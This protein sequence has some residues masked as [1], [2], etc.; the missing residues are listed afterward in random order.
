MI[1]SRF[2]SCFAAVLLMTTVAA[3][4]TDTTFTFQGELN[5]NGVPANAAFNMVFSLF[6][7]ANG[8]ILIG[9]PNVHGAV[10]VVDGKFAAELDFGA[11]AF[12]DNRWLEIEINGVPL[13]PRTP[14]THAPY[15][16]QTRGIFVNDAGLVG[17]ANNNPQSTLQVTQT[18][19]FE[20]MLTVEQANGIWAF[21]IQLR[22]SLMK[23]AQLIICF[24]LASGDN[25]HVA[26]RRIRRSPFRVN[27]NSTE[28]P[29]T[30]RLT[31][32]CPC[33]TRP[34][35]GFRLAQRT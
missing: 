11:A 8:G 9:T 15:A 26:Q 35:V 12:E 19:T 1:F 20:N 7:S 17:V 21:R 10:P 32:P 29:S 22:S 24:A 3:A 16:I 31:S 27:S 6:D 34:A 13:T 23:L 2:M 5:E 18:E 28:L 14:V 25:R 33:G 4:Q 30:V